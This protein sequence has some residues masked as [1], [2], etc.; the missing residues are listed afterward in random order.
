[1]SGTTTSEYKVQRFGGAAMPND[2]SLESWLNDMAEERWTLLTV[3][4]GV[5]YF[6]RPLNVPFNTAVPH[7]YQEGDVLHCTMGEWTGHPTSYAYAWQLDG[8]D[9]GT[10]ADYHVDP[11]DEGKTATC[12]VTATN[13]AGS[14]TAPPSNGVVIA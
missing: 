13:A 9:A 8:A 2:A 1:M 14:G 4:A 6:V 7:V 3:D 12:V 11:V 10:S 5:G